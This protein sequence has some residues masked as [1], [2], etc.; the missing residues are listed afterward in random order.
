[1]PARE[2]LFLSE[3]I[4]LQQDGCGAISAPINWVHEPLLNVETEL[5]QVIGTLASSALSRNGSNDTAHWHFF[6][7]SPGNGKSAATGKLARKFLSEMC[8]IEDT[9]GIAIDKLNARQLPY[10]LKVYE[11]GK[12]YASIWI[13][14]DASVIPDPFSKDADPARALVEMLKEASDHGVSLVVCTNRG[15]LE[16]VFGRHYLDSNANRTLWFRAVK[17]ALGDAE[18]VESPFSELTNTKRV[19]SKVA[20]VCTPLDRRSLVLNR[21]T[22]GEIVIKAADQSNWTSC[23][24]CDARPHCPFYQNR[25]WLEHDGRRSNLIK[26]LQRAE[27]LSGRVV[28]FREALAFLSFLLAG[29]PHDYPDASPCKWVHAKLVSQDLFALLS[30]RIYASIFSASTPLGLESMPNIRADQLRALR[31]LRDLPGAASNRTRTALDFVLKEEAWISSDVG[32]VRLLGARGTFRDMD[33]FNDV[34]PQGFHDRWDEDATPFSE[35][36]DWVSDLERDCAKCWKELRELIENSG[37]ASTEIYRALARW[38]TAFTYRAGG[39]IEDKLNF[40]QEVDD[41]IKTLAIRGE[42]EDEK[43]LA[44]IDEMQQLIGEIL[45]PEAE[46]TR[47]SIFGRLGGSWARNSLEPKLNPDAQHENIALLIKFG[48]HHPIPFQSWAFAWLKRR[49]DRGMAMTSFPVEYLDTAQDAL[50]RAASE[51]GYFLADDDVEIRIQLPGGGT[52]TLKRTH[53]RVRVEGM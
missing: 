30:R 26:L 10:L 28:V 9:D 39:L 51:S 50:A 17:V 1:M 48:N 52:A 46:G 8:R 53:G 27:V 42:S 40:A 38:I 36:E 41:L 44:Q 29:C 32:V 24:D 7:G 3:L 14:Q 11:Q 4:T 5:D 13:A 33:P 12:N 6:V 15:V 23:S 18:R 2:N 20:I 19:F 37:E 31:R 35:S 45:H 49:V 43:T 22:F 34:L 21:N 47:I 25:R 16:R